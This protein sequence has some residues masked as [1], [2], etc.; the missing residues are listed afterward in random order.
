[1]ATAAAS[2]GKIL[3]IDDHVDLAENLAEILEGAGYEAVTASSAEAGLQRIASGGVVA[4]ITD[5][6]LPGRNGV[7]LIAE[8]RRRGD[9]MPAVVMSAFTDDATVARARA[10]GAIDVLT[11]PVVL[12]RLMSAVA[13]MTKN[14]AI[15]LLVED[16][17]ALAENFAEAL[18]ARGHGAVICGSL[19]EVR[20]LSAA[21]RA[22]V[23]DYRLP[24]G[25]GVD[26]A[27]ALLARNA[28]TRIL[29]I[30]G[31]AGELQADPRG[32]IAPGAARLEKPI[33]LDDLVAWV[34]RALE[35]GAAERPRR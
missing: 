3:I 23:L 24:D 15:V 21:P 1:M 31:H 34:A 19:A 20:A 30:S 14:D 28:G 22:A 9:H 35:H 18:N 2:L 12:E 8:L 27:E 17:R 11:K 16:N 4:L 29:F 5:Y 10:I 7:E 25:T 13:S 32:E 33:D 26:V 6:R